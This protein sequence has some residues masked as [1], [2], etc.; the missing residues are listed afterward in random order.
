M[1]GVE[2]LRRGDVLV[3]YRTSDGQGS[4]RF[5]SV[6]TS[7]CVV[8]ECRDIGS[9]G[10]REEFLAYCRPYSVF[11]DQ[12]LIDLW[13]RRSYPK[14]VRFTYNIAFGRRPNRGRLIDEVGLSEDAYWG[15]LQLTHAQL[16]HIATLGEVNESLV[17]DQA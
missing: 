13:Q 16:K 10:S 11:T 17:V 7:L 15:F 12:E 9:F 6:A 5:R 1:R 2:N 14:I 4:A 3:V 8:E